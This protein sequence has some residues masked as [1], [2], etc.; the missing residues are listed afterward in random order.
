[1]NKILTFEN[2]FYA[3]K[4]LKNELNKNDICFD[5]YDYA[6]FE[7]DLEN[8]INKLIKEIEEGSYEQDEIKILPLPKKYDEEEKIKKVR[9]YFYVPV[10]TQL[11]WMA[12][13][14]QILQLD[15]DFKFWNYGNRI[16]Y[17]TFYEEEIDNRNVPKKK[18]KLAWYRHT[19]KNLYRK[20]QQSWPLFKKHIS[21]TAKMLYSI[22]LDD[23]EN[24]IRENN[25][26][27]EDKRKVK[28]LDYNYLIKNSEKE[29]KE[30]YWISVD[31]KDFYP[32]IQLDKL[33]TIFKEKVNNIVDDL[34]PEFIEK[35]FCFRIENLSNFQEKELKELSIDSKSKEFKSLPT[36]LFVA[37]F[38]SNLFLTEIDR[39]IEKETKNDNIY[40]FRFVDDNVI[41]ADN[42]EKLYNF[43]K[44]YQIIL[45]KYGITINKD[46]TEPKEFRIYTS[47]FEQNNDLSVDI[48]IDL[49]KALLK[50]N[51]KQEINKEFVTNF[52]KKEKNKVIKACLVD[53]E[54]IRPFINETLKKV[55][56]ISKTNFDLLT[57][58]EQ[59]NFIEDITHLFTINLD[60]REIREDTRLSFCA[61]KLCSFLKNK[62]FFSIEDYEKY[63]QELGKN[64]INKNIIKSLSK[65]RKQLL[66]VYLKYLLNAIEI[67]HDKRNLYY[68]I[69]EF[70]ANSG[71]DINIFLKKVKKIINK[72]CN[73]LA[74][75][76][77]LQ[78]LFNSLSKIIVKQFSISKENSNYYNPIQKLNA[79]FFI[80]NV[81]KEKNINF[82][83][84]LKDK[85]CREDGILDNSFNNLQLIVSI[86]KEEKIKKEKLSTEEAY[87]LYKQFYHYS[88]SYIRKL[89]YEK[90]NVNDNLENDYTVLNEYIQKDKIANSF[91]GLDKSESVILDKIEEE[92][93]KCKDEDKTIKTNYDIHNVFGNNIESFQVFYIGIR[94]LQL[95]QKESDNAIKIWNIF[96]KGKLYLLV[97]KY[98]EFF[99][100]GIRNN[101]STDTVG[102]LKSCLMSSIHRNEETEKIK[103]E[104]LTQKLKFENYDDTTFD[105]NPLS[106]LKDLQYRIE[107]IKNKLKK[108][109]I[110][111][112]FNTTEPKT[113]QIIKKEL[114]NSKKI[115]RKEYSE[116][117]NIS[118]IQSKFNYK[119]FYTV[120][121][122]GTTNEFYDL[123][124]SKQIFVPNIE[125]ELDNAFNR[126]KVDRDKI[127]ADIILIP[128]ISTPQSYS[129][130]LKIYSEEL[131]SIIIAGMNYSIQGNRVRNYVSIFVPKT[132]SNKK[133]DN[134]SK[135]FEIAKCNP[136]T[137]ENDMF[138]KCNLKLDK[139][140]NIYLFDAG[141]KGKFGIIIC[142]DIFDIERFSIYRGY[143][144]NLFIIAYNQD[145][146]LFAKFAETLARVLFCNVTICNTGIFSGSLVY[147]PYEESYK[148][149]VYRVEGLDLFTTQTL[150]LPLKDIITIQKIRKKLAGYKELPPAYPKFD[151]L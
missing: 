87:C 32:S 59:R 58:E 66:E 119:Q 4:K 81:I 123:R 95:L 78:I 113:R 94:L 20:W 136:A 31:F 52:L 77:I 34:N 130:K 133:I 69:I 96:T 74:I 127:K 112:N 150:S 22:T 121:N 90:Y 26:S 53:K 13:V 134:K 140:D 108:F 2:F 61:T 122:K 68:K 89:I 117:I 129:R 82:L 5:I 37:G 3:W 54:F 62:Y 75:S 84:D 151:L 115:N 29:I 63:L 72:R 1:M 107:Q 9:Q 47:F 145:T 33:K 114:L 103:N 10:R 100:D 40:I 6:S 99:I 17:S 80:D 60:N 86:V 125:T 124:L 102:L 55:S 148:R 131:E 42:F 98:K 93:T 109:T 137:D 16:Y 101:I 70:I 141:F 51:F 126:I 128:E 139:D 116:N 41:L 49:Y 149:F 91:I 45:D 71:L 138:D 79:K 104:I 85:N 44:K 25:N 15:Y 144:Q 39:E 147:V 21:I 92:I 88:F 7:V 143:I 8:N 111:N 106:N 19:S 64:K 118:I 36:G 142:S 132:F 105:G 14:N 97:C 110:N 38:L 30:L 28:Y 48:V 18:L 65:K 146:K 76:A 73:H 24:K 35:L 50:E 83:K 27:I 43:Y 46:K 135:C 23:D 11:V 57:I 67:Y 12:V 120:K 56:N